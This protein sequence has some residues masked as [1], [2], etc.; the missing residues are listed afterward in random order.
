MTKHVSWAL[1]GASLFALAACGGGS[2]GDGGDG[3][4]E[5][6]LE[7]KTGALRELSVSGR[8]LGGVPDALADEAGL[9]AKG[10]EAGEWGKVPLRQI[11][12]NRPKAACP[13]GG[14]Y[15]LDSGSKARDFSYFARDDVNVGFE[16]RIDDDCE[17]EA[18]AGDLPEGLVGT[19]RFDGPFE[20]GESATL[21]DGSRLGYVVDGVTNNG[22]RTL[23]IQ[24]RFGRRSSN[25]SVTVYQDARGSFGAVE[26]LEA[27]S[28]AVDVRA[29][30][31]YSLDSRSTITGGTVDYSQF[32][33]LGKA[34]TGSYFQGV[35]DGNDRKFNGTYTY[36]TSKCDGGTVLASTEET[37]RLAATGGRLYP[38]DG[39]LRLGSGTKFAVLEFNGD[40][41]ATLNLNGTTSTLTPTE[42]RN[43][44]DNS[45]C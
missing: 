45:P 3:P 33:E 19:K 35:R 13:E 31:A 20:S 21:G 9:A 44:I 43:A 34:D 7:T 11:V 27:S 36:A 42:V 18:A 22:V 10:L 12:V 25:P 14:S 2:G 4:A 16:R 28:G 37:I 6:S 8:V 41:G 32:V 23:Y 5:F 29:I 24:R 40:G 30:Y 39:R 26:Q 15:T 38:V 1:A 17:F